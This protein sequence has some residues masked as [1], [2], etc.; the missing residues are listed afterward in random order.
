M[1]FDV[2]LNRAN[3]VIL[4]LQVCQA[5]ACQPSSG[6]VCHVSRCTGAP[7]FE[8]QLKPTGHV[9]QTPNWLNGVGGRIPT[10]IVAVPLAMTTWEAGTCR[11]Q[12]SNCS[13][14]KI[15]MQT[16]QINS[17]FKMVVLHLLL[18]PTGAIEVF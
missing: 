11:I 2:D 14:F 7:K 15:Q 4:T 18:G 12:N 13:G 3:R 10:L 1:C 6:G 9:A 8:F 5:L 17:E 16:G